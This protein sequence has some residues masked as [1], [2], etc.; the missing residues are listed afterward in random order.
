MPYTLM[1]IAQAEGA[2]LQQTAVQL[3][4]ARTG[5]VFN[6]LPFRTVDEMEWKENFTL[7]SSRSQYRAIN[8][9]P[10]Q[11]EYSR[12]EMTFG[13]SILGDRI[14]M[15]RI[16]KR[17]A[18]G[19]KSWDLALLEK[20]AGM[21]FKYNADFIKGSSA[22]NV[23]EFDGLQRLFETQMDSAQTLNT[24]NVAG[25]ALSLEVLDEAIDLCR[26]GASIMVM[27]KAMKRKFAK[28]GRDSAVAGYVENTR[29]KF[30]MPV[31]MY[32]GI[33]IIT[34]NDTRNADTILPFN[35]VPVINGATGVDST[36]IY[37]LNLGSQGFYGAQQFAPT[38]INHGDVPGTVNSSTDLE[39]TASLGVGHDQA[40]VRISGINNV[41]IVA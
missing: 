37:L 11:G 2:D 40:G 3:E 29:D 19:M 8:E 13:M 20:A 15:D 10:G 7:E 24:G 27:S 21:G 32:N 6:W 14:Q 18:E 39:W 17:R 22:D 28:A 1:D 34:I 12:K 16:L 9:E 36:S 35:E 41:D 33:P 25:A 31:T 30:G 26:S 23:R 5:S 38:V 4:I